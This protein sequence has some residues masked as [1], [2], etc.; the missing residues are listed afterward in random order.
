M[1]EAA[2]EIPLGMRELYPY[3]S[4]YIGDSLKE[5]GAEIAF[6]VHGGHIW[7]IV[8]A[9]SNAGIKT[10]TVRHE[11][12]AVYAA[13]AYSKVTNKPGIAYATVGPGTANIVSAVQQ[14]F[15]SRSPV[16]VLLGGH[17]IEV[18]RLYTTIQEAYA[19][20]L[21]TG[22]SKWCQ[23]VPQ[24]D[25]YKQFIARAFKVAQSYPKGPVVLEFPLSGLW[26][27]IPPL[28]RPGIFGEHAHY[29]PKWRGEETDKPLPPS[30]GDPQLIEKAVKMIYEAKSPTIFAG[31]G[32][33]WSEASAELVEFAELARVPVSNRRIARGAMPETHPLYFSSRAADPIMRQSDVLLML[34]MKVGFFD[35]YGAGWP[36]AIQV[37]E[38]PEHI[39]TFLKTAMV[40]LGSPKVVLRQMIDYI[41]AHNLQPPP[42]RAEWISKVQEGNKTAWDRLQARAEKYKEHK[43]IH[44]GWLSKVIADTMEE[45]YEGKNRVIVDGFTISDYC[46]PFLRARYSGQIMDAS[47]QAGVGHGIGMAI[48]AAFGD[49]ETRKRP[50]LALM[51]DAGMGVAG[52]DIETALRFKLPIVYLVTNNNG[53]LLSLKYTHY[54]KQWDALGPQDR[55]FGSECLPDIRYDKMFEA[56][57]CHGEL[58]EEP[59]QI[60]PALERAFKAAEGGQTAVVNVLVDPSV[61]NRAT[62]SFAYT[63]CLAHI[64]WDRLA[65]RGKAVRRNMMRWLPWDKLG[66][67]PMPMPDPWEPLTEEE[68][69]P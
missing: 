36:P 60:R 45:L 24:P 42:E 61:G 48:G 43:R 17:E 47:E 52:M 20:D 27:P 11:Q 6:G 4:M 14:A 13:E 63:M 26:T 19:T 40:I 67:P 41:K 59:A 38:S 66:I 58:V 56:L 65:K 9:I 21:M 28:V 50:V 57:G 44:P 7:Q 30:G 3:P 10:V 46:P 49:P 54:G 18:D 5:H 37:N 51:G 39:W 25:Q 32:V 35:G 15:L 12:T 31:D 29:R 33:H 55:E 68:M 62:Y 34:G 53:W 23:R 2:Q 64:P 22:I 69:T 8:D 16:I 1:A